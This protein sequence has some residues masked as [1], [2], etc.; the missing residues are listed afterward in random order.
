MGKLGLIGILFS[1]TYLF[2]IACFQWDSIQD[3]HLLDLNAFGDFLAGVF[4]PIAI[5]WLVLGFF[6]QGAELRNSVETLKLQANELA[7]SVEQQRELVIVTR[8]TLEHERNVLE[9]QEKKRK[10]SLQ[11]DLII[12]FGPSLRTGNKFRLKLSIQSSGT[13]V[14]R[15]S[16]TLLDG[17]KK[18]L[19]I[20]R[21]YFK[22]GDKIE[23][24]RPD[25]EEHWPDTLNLRVSYSDR[26]AD[27]I[28]KQFI[29]GPVKVIDD[30]PRYSVSEISCE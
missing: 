3:I 26:E 5:F 9:T 10:S 13:A 15:F 4:G 30:W 21:P 29:V 20:E 23:R 1:L 18:Y 24:E 25:P 22:D 19:E 28:E 16:A 27:K 2:I 14:S 7:N 17:P 8:E 11:P 12:T 6:Q